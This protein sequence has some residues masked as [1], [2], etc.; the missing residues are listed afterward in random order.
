MS[1]SFKCANCGREEDYRDSLEAFCFEWKKLPVGGEFEDYCPEC[2][3]IRRVKMDA[4]RKARGLKPLYEKQTR[5]Q[6]IRTMI[7]GIG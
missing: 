4:L 6:R 1:E 7:G 5:W 3:D 2:E